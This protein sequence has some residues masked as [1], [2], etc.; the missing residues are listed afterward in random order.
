MMVRRRELVEDTSDGMP[1]GAVRVPTM[2]LLAAW[3]GEMILEKFIA[4]K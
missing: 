2:S 3:M 4:K 1:E